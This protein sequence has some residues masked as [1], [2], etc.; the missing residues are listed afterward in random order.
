MRISIYFLVLIAFIGCSK[1][2]T[3]NNNNANQN[4]VITTLS[5]TFN[6]GKIQFLGDVTNEGSG[7]SSRGFCWGTN[8]NPTLEGSNY[9]NA[10]GTGL[11]NFF[12]DIL[13]PTGITNGATYNVRAYVYSSSGI[14][15]GNNVS[16]TT[17]QLFSTTSIGAK[18][19]YTTQA[20]L[21]GNIIS[22]N[23]YNYDVRIKGFCYGTSANPTI[24]GDTVLI[25]DG[26]LGD[27]S[28]KISSLI[29]NTTY[30]FRSFGYEV[31]NQVFYGEN[32]SFKTAGQIGSSGGN[33]FYDKGEFTDGWRYLELAPNDIQN[34]NSF[35]IGWGCSGTAVNQTLQT[36]GSGLNNTNRIISQCASLNSAA[37][38]CDNYSL[39]G[40]SD[41]FLPSVNE[42]EI[43]YKSS[44][45]VYN[46]ASANSQEIWSSSE[47][48]ASSSYTYNAYYGY[49]TTESKG[50]GYRVR[51]IRRF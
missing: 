36:V 33:I 51:P 2:N 12:I 47:F 45:N 4:P 31:A 38:V 29:P 43:M 9:Q 14:V 21:Y 3:G 40:L 30:Y 22:N 5:P 19:I 25:Q 35:L 46:L 32:K 34:N 17:P 10:D 44:I 39:N 28:K 41:W 6:N 7:I 11:G 27:F 8:T 49:K 26:F 16:F 48:G 50:L 42:L 18:E 23:A 1:P 20:T 37:R 13:Y 24:N 15:Y